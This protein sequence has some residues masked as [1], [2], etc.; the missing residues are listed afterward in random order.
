MT[1][2][3]FIPLIGI[4]GLLVYGLFLHKPLCVQSAAK[5]IA[6]LS[7]VGLCPA[8]VE[9]SL[10]TINGQLLAALDSGDEAAEIESALSSLGI[11]FSRDRFQGRYQ[12]VIRHPSSNFHAIRIHIY[13]DEENKFRSIEVND[14]FTV[15]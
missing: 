12:G 13:V 10:E 4:F 7:S 3:K 2:V 11:S 8:F 15:L 1:R 9:T 5:R 6:I 14:S